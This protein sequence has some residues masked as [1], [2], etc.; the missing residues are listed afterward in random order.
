[1]PAVSVEYRNMY[2]PETELRTR[3]C[4]LVTKKCGTG[5]GPIESDTIEGMV[6]VVDYNLDTRSGCEMDGVRSSRTGCN[7]Y[8]TSSFLKSVLNLQMTYIIIA[9]IY[10]QWDR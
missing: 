5:K 4:L 3:C 10:E 9:H 8:R 2:Y 1:M 7:T 6:F